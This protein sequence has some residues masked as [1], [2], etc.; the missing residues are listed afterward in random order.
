MVSQL[1]GALHVRTGAPGSSTS[2]HPPEN[3][4]GPQQMERRNQ[5]WPGHT[6]ERHR[7]GQ[8]LNRINMREPH[9][10][11]AHPRGQAHKVL[12]ESL[13]Q[14][15]SPA[16]LSCHRGT[17]PWGPDRTEEQVMIISQAAAAALG[18][19]RG[20]EQQRSFQN[21]GRG[22]FFD[23]SDRVMGVHFMFICKAKRML[24]RFSVHVVC[25]LTTKENR[26]P[27][28]AYLSTTGRAW[29]W[30]WHPRGAAEWVRKLCASAL[31]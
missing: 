28:P 24:L 20:S 25:C 2:E 18:T 1:S 8:G 26:P 15:Q 16:A 4:Q 17:Q 14:V 12:A 13:R 7:P 10:H 22:L 3:P 21:P 19:G 9:R 11:N 29:A 30:A 6:V 31:A 5:L 27:R 23:R